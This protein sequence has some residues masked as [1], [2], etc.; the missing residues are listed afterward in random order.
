MFVIAAITIILETPRGDIKITVT[1]T[2][3]VTSGGGVCGY[4]FQGFCEVSCCLP[5]GLQ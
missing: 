2:D 1:D 3:T 5:R 4:P